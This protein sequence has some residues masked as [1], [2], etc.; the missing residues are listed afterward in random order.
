MQGTATWATLPLVRRDFVTVV[1]GLP[2]SGT[3][4]VQQMLAAGGFDVWTDGVRAADPDNPRGYFELE[5]ARRLQADADWVARARGRA[6]KVVSAQVRHLPPD[7]AYRLVLVRR[8]LHEVVASQQR[9]LA[10]RAAEDAAGP[11]PERLVAL[12]DAELR[13][14]ERWLRARPAFARLDLGHAEL[15]ADPLAAARR[16]EAFLGAGL[17]VAAMARV[18][19]PGLYRQRRGTVPA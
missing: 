4:L 14:L 15:L 8:D 1:S 12:Y 17:D 7:L 19:E 6:I 3:S 13:E 11:P 9:M 2:R 5:A 16:L 18:V 10:R